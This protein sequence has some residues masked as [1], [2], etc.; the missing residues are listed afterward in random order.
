MAHRDFLVP[1][2]EPR[3]PPGRAG[4]A[5][6]RRYVLAVMESMLYTELNGDN[7]GKLE[8]WVFGGIET[9]ADCQVLIRAVR[10]LQAEMRRRSGQ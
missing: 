6:A 5:A 4:R 2:A 3:F 7:L 9:E 8:G 10:A 1:G